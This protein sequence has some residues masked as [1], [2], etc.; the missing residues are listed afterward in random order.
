MSDRTLVPLCDVAPTTVEW[1]WPD[2]I[3][4]RGITLLDGDPG[5]GKSLITYDLTARVTTGRPMPF[6]ENVIGPAGV[7]LLQAEDSLGATVRPNIEAAGANLSKIAVFDR[8]RFA[9]KPFGLSGDISV[10]EEAIDAT[11]AKLVV[12][13]PLPAFLSNPNSEAT[14]RNALSKLADLAE[15]KSLAVVIVRHLTKGGSSNTK[16]RGGGSIGIIGAARSALLVGHDPSSDCPHQHVLALNK[17]NLADAV[18]L[19]YRT[20]KRNE[21]I[22]VEWLGESQ[23]AVDALSGTSADGFGYSQLDEAC[24]VLYTILAEDEAPT[25]ATEVKKQAG[26]ALV[27]PRTLKRAKKK[28]SVRS[29]RVTTAPA[30]NEGEPAAHWVWELPNNDVLLKPFRE[31]AMREQTQD[32]L[33]DIED[34]TEPSNPDGMTESEAPLIEPPKRS[35]EESE[36]CSEAVLE[37]PG[38]RPWDD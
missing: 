3:P 37:S 16:Y 25:A 14:V 29:R 19:T 10:I 35:W 15:E 22:T 23:H 32:I 4:L 26:E 5:H 13:D 31:R 27:S 30:A 12:I 8:R 38:R 20:V 2:R 6:T 18:S 11:G 24:Y 17:S 21:S 28:L 7:V 36:P 33:N 9:E 1:L 34:V